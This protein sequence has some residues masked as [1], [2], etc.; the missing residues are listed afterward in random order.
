MRPRSSCLALLLLSGLCAVPAAAQSTFPP[1]SVVQALLDDAVAERP[2]ARV[3]LL[4]FDSYQWGEY[5]T[6]TPE[7]LSAVSGYRPA[8]RVAALRARAEL[9]VPPARVPASRP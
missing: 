4:H 7:M 2:D 1:D 3:W 6:T 9:L 5:K 8:D